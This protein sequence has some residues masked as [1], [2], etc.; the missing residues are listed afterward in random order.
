[1]TKQEFEEKTFGYHVSQPIPTT[2]VLKKRHRYRESRDTS[3]NDVH[4]ARLE[5]GNPPSDWWGLYGS[6]KHRKEVIRKDIER[7]MNHEI[8]ILERDH[9]ASKSPLSPEKLL[10]GEREM[11]AIRNHMSRMALQ[12]SDVEGITPHEVT[13][14]HNPDY[15]SALDHDWAKDE[16]AY[17]ESTEAWMGHLKNGLSRHED[18]TGLLLK[19]SQ[20]YKAAGDATAGSMWRGQLQSNKHGE[21]MGRAWVPTSNVHSKSALAHKST[22]DQKRA[23]E[24]RY[25]ELLDQTNANDNSLTHARGVENWYQNV[26]NAGRRVSEKTSSS[27]SSSSPKKESSSKMLSPQERDQQRLERA[28]LRAERKAT[29]KGLT[30]EEA[31]RVGEASNKFRVDWKEERERAQKIK[32]LSPQE[33]DQQRLERAQLRAERKATYKGLT[34]EEALRIGEASNTFRVDWDQE[35]KLSPPVKMLSP[36]DREHQRLVQA[37]ARARRREMEGGN[38]SG[39]RSPDEAKKVGYNNNFGTPK[40][41]AFDISPK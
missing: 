23:I 15:K 19:G 2:R 14:A 10:G 20:H 34:K 8:K 3:L 32:L 12:S 38:Y 17:L 22:N 21:S 4:H 1:M 35:R 13:R 29:Y 39:I 36:K 25:K 28:Q 24:L 18:S 9:T 7:H 33:R 40:G 31:L 11:R 41:V 5:E 6:D 37:A 16:H 27:P 26:G 30:K